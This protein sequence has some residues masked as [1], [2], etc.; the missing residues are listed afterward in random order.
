MNKHLHIISFNIPWPANYGGIIDVFHKIRTLHGMGVKII[1]HCFEYERPHA[2]ELEAYCEQVYYYKRN[3]GI[4]PNITLLPYNVYS[5]KCP[6]LLENLL[7]DDYPILFE[8]LHC[9]YY[10]GDPRL[11][12]RKKIYRE[13]N[14]EHDYFRHLALAEKNFI[15]KSFFRVEAYRF[16]RYQQVLEHADLMLAVSTSDTAY[17][18]KTFPERQ[19]EYMPSFHPNEQIT[20]QPGQ[21]DFVLYHGK[22]SVPE[23][24]QAALYLV[25]HVFRKL[26]FTCIIAGMDPPTELVRAVAPYP[27]IRIE[28][29]PSEEWMN[30]LIREAQIHVLIT[31]QDTGL[32]LKLLNSIFA[33]RYAVVN[34]LMTVGSGLEQ[35]CHIADTPKA[36]IQTCNQLMTTTLSPEAIEQRANLL[37]PLYSNT[38]QGER[39]FNLI[40]L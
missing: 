2:P 28:A 19:V 24:T 17:L 26:P 13:S 11:K 31:F 12:G 23:N 34:R 30:T 21:S 14:I 25:K 27:N 33:G 37:F 1:L 4:L 29:N 9:C 6:E 22:L 38:H 35:L 8:G 18:Q 7:K 20:A 16:E 40:Y 10:I 39:L 32:K 3:T 5:R 15:K 36:I